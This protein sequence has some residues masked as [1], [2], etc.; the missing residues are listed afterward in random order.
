MGFEF[1][2]GGLLTLKHYARN[3]ILLVRLTDKA[4]NIGEKTLQ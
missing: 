3:V 4:A 1:D 2:I